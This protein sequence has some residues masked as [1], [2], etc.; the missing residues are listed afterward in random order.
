[1]RNSDRTLFV[2]R[3]EL[4][5]V[6]AIAVVI[7]AQAC[8]SKP[9][10]RPGS[11][12]QA[13]PPPQ[14]APSEPSPPK[15][16]AKPALLPETVAARLGVDPAELKWSPSRA[17][18]AA[19]IAPKDRSKS[20]GSYRLAVFSAAGKRIA[21]VDA[22]R[23]GAVGDLG[24]L[25]ESR[26]VYR[27]TPPAPP[28]KR[29]RA[30]KQTVKKKTPPVP[31]MLYAIQPLVPVAAP[32]ICEGQRFTFSPNG[33]HIA[34]VNGEPGQEWLGADGAQVYPRRG[35]TTIQGEPAWS[36]DGH[37]LALIEGGAKPTL[38]V[39]VE[40]DNPSGDNFWPLPP[41]ATDPAM[42]VFWAGP[43]RLV[44]GREITK[45]MFTTSFRRANP[46]GSDK[47]SPGL[48]QP[49]DGSSSTLPRATNDK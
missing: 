31:T 48:M 19:A 20:A 42:R 8:A 7:G 23:P 6:V 16:D 46:V 27:I 43:G 41:D 39:L 10:N 11:S 26:L 35:V 5:W 25:G 49:H 36:H 2:L 3:A 40:F 4:A 38:V 18:Y 22:T 47:S 14:A 24:F 44:V 1:M 30:Q 13:P 21:E 33:D 45:P 12:L 32:M 34:W 28:H 37:S 15:P 29:T 17:S 9:A